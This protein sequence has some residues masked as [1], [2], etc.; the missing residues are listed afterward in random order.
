MLENYLIECSQS[1]W[2]SPCVLVLKPDKTYRFCT[3]FHKVNVVTKAD[4]YP[5]PRIEDC[6]DRIGHSR[7]VSKFDLLKGYWQVPLTNRAKEISA[8][9]TPDGLYQY[10]VMPFGMQNAP[11]TFQRLINHIIRD[12]PGCEAYIDDVIIY[13]DRWE[14]HVKQIHAFFECL[15]AANLTINL[16]KSEFGHACVTFLGHVVGQGVVEPIIA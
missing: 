3:D 10:K 14:D 15:K 16:C 2:S 6:I 7:Y 8:F 13:S 1:P 11:A 12:V 9:V 5:L 4:S